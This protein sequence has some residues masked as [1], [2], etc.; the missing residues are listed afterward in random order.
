MNDQ[1]L[2]RVVNRRA[3]F[4]E[5]LKPLVDGE[6]F[7]AAIIVDAGSIDVFH[8]KERNAIRGHARVIKLGD[9]WMIETGEQT[10]LAEKSPHDLIAVHPVPDELERD[11]TVQL[12]ILRE[13]NF[14][15]PAAADQRN[16]LVIADDLAR[17][18]RA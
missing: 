9:V 12:S 1:M 6:I 17:R 2:V 3:N 11:P 16:D 7:L 18:E 8:R 4:A 15:H 14:A 13:I 10:L 5:E